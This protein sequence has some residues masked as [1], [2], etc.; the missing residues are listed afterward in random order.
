MYNNSA[1]TN[2]AF[3]RSTTLA[4][5]R[6][7]TPLGKNQE[8]EKKKKKK[9]N[10][11]NINSNLVY[12]RVV[13]PRSSSSSSSASQTQI[14]EKV[15]RNKS[16]KTTTTTGA[17]S[18]AGLR[19]RSLKTGAIS[20]SSPSSPFVASKKENGNARCKKANEKTKTAAVVQTS[21]FFF[22]LNNKNTNHNNKKRTLSSQKNVSARAGGG[23]IAEENEGGVPESEL[24]D[25]SERANKRRWMMVFSLFVAFVLCNLDKVNMSVA[26][27]PMAKSFGWTSTQKGL[28]ASAF[29]WG[30]AFTQ[31]PGGWLSSKYGGKAVL[32]YG[33]MLWSLGTLI[34]PWCA[35]LGMGPLLTSRFIVGLGEGVA[36]SAATGILAKTIPPT[37]RSKAVTATFGGLDVGSLFGLLIA[38]PI[39]LYL[40]GWQAC[41]RCG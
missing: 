25:L 12:S 22:A 7:V 41:V 40:G 29:F 8:N 17:R 19:R 31:I 34:A 38:P 37:Q 3:S 14:T 18:E 39:I 15:I 10:Y 32:F 9:K 23:A 21:S 33:V 30:Y 11:C 13:V 4:I 5:P 26:I 35:A 2:V 28:V 16:S 20:P 24:F 1:A 6:R 36:P 27:V